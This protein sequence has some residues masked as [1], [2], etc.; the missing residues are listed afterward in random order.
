MK[1]SFEHKFGHPKKTESLHSFFSGPSHHYNAVGGTTSTSPGKSCARLLSPKANGVKA[2][3]NGVSSS[4]ASNGRRAS[5]PQHPVRM[6]E[7]TPLAHAA[8]AVAKAGEDK[9]ETTEC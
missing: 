7:A 6:A 1:G 4:A 9:V 2:I 8:A 3:S 5:E